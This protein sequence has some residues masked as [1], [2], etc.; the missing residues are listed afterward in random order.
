M[1]TDCG[2]LASLARL[3]NFAVSR[4][5]GISKDLIGG[6]NALQKRSSCG[7]V[8]RSMSASQKLTQLTYPVTI[9]NVESLENDRHAL[10]RLCPALH[11]SGGCRGVG[12]SDQRERLGCK[13]RSPRSVSESS[14]RSSM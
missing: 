5:Y 3:K 12:N 7:P 11:R 9:Y 14:A 1:R 2:R 4:G 6:I 8:Q 10:V 13:G